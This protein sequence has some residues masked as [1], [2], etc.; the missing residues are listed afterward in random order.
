MSA[1]KPWTGGRLGIVMM[2]ALGDAVHVLPLLDAVKNLARQAGVNFQFDPRIAA[3]TNQPNVTIRF[4]NVTAEDAL[5]ALDHEGPQG[6]HLVG[7]RVHG[8]DEPQPPRHERQGIDGVA[9]EKQRHGQH[10]A[11]AHETL[12]RLYQAGDNQGKGGEDRRPQYYHRQYA[13]QRQRVPAQAHPHQQR[14][15][16]NYHHLRERAHPGGKRLTQYN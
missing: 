11:N 6:V 13:H 4:E 7:E 8:R 14:Q 10:L 9:G 1:L 16:I 15:Q 12:A 2:S 5:A 3:M